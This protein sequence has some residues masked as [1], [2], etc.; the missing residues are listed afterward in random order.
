M[1]TERKRLH[2]PS[3]VWPELGN[4][5]LCPSSFSVREAGILIR[6]RWSWDTSPPSSRSASFQNEAALPYPNSQPVSWF[7]DLSFSEQDALGLGNKTRIGPRARAGE[8]ESGL[9]LQEGAL[10]AGSPSVGHQPQPPF[11]LRPSSAENRCRALS[12]CLTSFLAGRKPMWVQCW[13]SQLD[14]GYFRGI[15]APHQ[16]LLT[17]TG[18][19][20]PA[21][22]CTGQWVDRLASKPS[23]MGRRKEKSTHHLQM[24]VSPGSWIWFQMFWAPWVMFPTHGQRETVWINSKM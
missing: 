21:P 7:I 19:P 16:D 8:W 1:A 15:K 2:I 11:P 5:W 20:P 10:P 9:S 24:K 22:E 6:G 23:S 13:P 4:I 14:P 17:S 18:K 3:G 12:H